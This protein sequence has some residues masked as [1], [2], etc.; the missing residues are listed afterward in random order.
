MAGYPKKTALAVQLWT[1]VIGNW[2]KISQAIDFCVDIL[3]RSE[4][5]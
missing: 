3:K 2:T 5:A 4:N 1:N